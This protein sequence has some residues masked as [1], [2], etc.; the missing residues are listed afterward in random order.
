[1]E[2]TSPEQFR[3]QL[4]GI[5]AEM[6]KKVESVP[7]K[8]RSQDTHKE[9]IHQVV[10]EKLGKA[11]AGA[12]PAVPHTTDP[13]PAISSRVEELVQ[14]A[15][16]KDLDGAIKRARELND[17]LTLDAF[18]DALVGELYDRLVNEGKIKPLG[19]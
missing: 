19:K 17:P 1:M 10:G 3:N 12:P 7:E 11:D 9:A 6:N 13:S 2:T 18:H 8:Q 4:E 14:E 16:S 5:H 15:V